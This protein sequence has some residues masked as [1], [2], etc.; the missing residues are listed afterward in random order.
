MIEDLREKDFTKTV[1]GIKLVVTNSVGGLDLNP[2][3]LQSFCYTNDPIKISI[4][5]CMIYFGRKDISVEFENEFRM[6][7]FHSILNTPP[8]PHIIAKLL[9]PGISA[10]ESTPNNSASKSM[11]RKKTHTSNILQLRVSIKGISPPI[12]RKLLVNSDTTIHDL[13]LMIQAAFGWY[14]YHL[15]E[16][17]DGHNNYTKPGDWDELDANEMDSTR[18]TLGDFNLTVGG[19]L[20][21]LYD[22]GDGWEHTVSVQKILALDASIS[23][24]ACIGGKR[25]GPPEDCGGIYGYYDVLKKA[26]DPQ[27][28]EHNETV[29]WLGE[30]D[31]EEF[32]LEFADAQVKNYKNMEDPF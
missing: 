31:P 21:Y 14:N 29:E 12:W 30:Y 24:P 5:L 2:L 25:N 4:N 18:V 7:L 23:L 19:K 11:R 26:T 8:D 10:R 27:D 32:D 13:H 15:Y 6:N 28:P 17:S 3:P 22:F 9:A 20:T 1:N 16:F